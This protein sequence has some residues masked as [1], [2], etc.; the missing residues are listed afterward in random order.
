MR[1]MALVAAAS[2]AVTAVTATEAAP[3]KK[4]VAYNSPGTVVVHRD[5]SG[6]T[7]TKIIVQK[8]SYLDGGTEVMPGENSD[9]Y[10]SSFLTHQASE[11]LGPNVIRIRRA[12]SPIRSIC[13]ART[14]PGPASNSDRSRALTLALRPR[15]FPSP[16]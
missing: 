5:E 11:G 8:R 10:R 9:T 6:R 3:L 16:R 2:F 7:R 14:T 13:R 4:R 15:A 12:R 1:L